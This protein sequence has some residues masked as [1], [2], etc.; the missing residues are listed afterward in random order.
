LFFLC[1][2]FEKWLISMVVCPSCSFANSADTFFCG[3]CRLYLKPVGSY[4]LLAEVGQGG[5]AV[6]YK[7]RHRET[8]EYAAIKVLRRELTQREDMTTRFMREAQILIELDNPYI[9][10]CYEYGDL[11]D[12]EL[13]LY[14]VMEWC[15][16]TTLYEAI[17]QQPKQRFAPAKARAICSQILLGLEHIHE[18]GIVHRDLKPGNIM[19]LTDTMGTQIK[20]LDFGVAW[21]DGESLTQSG[22]IIGSLMFMSPEQ[23]RAKK[24]LYGPATD[25]YAVGLLLS[26]M[27]TGAHPYGEF[28][29]EAMALQHIKETPS[30]LSSLCP[31]VSWSRGLEALVAKSLAKK[32]KKR[33]GSARD[34]LNELQR[35]AFPDLA[36]EETLPLV[37]M[38]D[39]D[40]SPFD[41]T[42]V[43]HQSVQP[44]VPSPP[45]PSSREPHSEWAFGVGGT[46]PETESGHSAVLG[47]R[48]GVSARRGTLGA[49]RW[50]WGALVTLLLIGAWWG[51]SM[52][53]EPSTPA[54]SD[55]SVSTTRREM[56]DLRATSLPERAGQVMEGSNKD[57]V[58]E[59]L[60]QL[61]FAWRTSWQSLA[62]SR[63]HPEAFK[64][65]QM[66]YDAEFQNVSTRETRTSQLARMRREA[67][68]CAW[69]R[70]RTSHYL[71]QGSTKDEA[72]IQFRQKWVCSTIKTDS[73]DSDDVQ[74]EILV[75]EGIKIL[76]WRRTPSGQW[77][78]W[79]TFWYPQTR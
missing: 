26:W 12:Q 44:F 5:F 32:A 68:R 62:K 28:T 16:G 7:A 11:R 37:S 51:L 66:L 2:C 58:P 65:F 21:V 76:R 48:E 10:R 9:A 27:L 25:L 52:Q 38:G 29:G 72:Y 74:G 20:L 49:S 55:A 57:G 18:R 42:G 36:T 47:E 43:A 40:V 78:I 14:L 4:E 79:R 19:L 61:V 34:M 75:K 64:R 33:F 6:V 39:G 56:P 23:I 71:L 8:G 53:W 69:L 15:E 41:D 70:V 73:P 77:R 35:V 31:G 50:K 63:Q 45:I 3:K 46:A 59:W 17:Q 60:K 24:E 13:G 22:M 67:R 1:G 54:A 30:S